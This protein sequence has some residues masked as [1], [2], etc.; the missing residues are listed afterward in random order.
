MMKSTRMRVTPD[1]YDTIVLSTSRAIASQSVTLTDENVQL[2]NDCVAALR[3]GGLLF[4][5]GQ[6]AR[7]PPYAVHLARQLTFKYWIALDIADAP[8]TGALK[9]SH[10]GLLLFWKP[11]G[12]FQINNTTVRVPHATCAACGK[13]LKDWGGKKHL[14][15]PTG[16]AL[17]D[18]WRDL[19]RREI[20][21]HVIPSDVLARI[22]ALTERPGMVFT[23]VVEDAVPAVADRGPAAPSRSPRT[24]GIPT[25][26]IHHTDCVSFLDS[27]PPGSFDLCFADP[28]YNLAKLYSD[29]DDA[30][31]AQEYLAW[32]DRWLTGM[33]RALKPGGALF[34]L[35]LPVWA[36]HHAVLLHRHLEFHHWIA[37]DALSEPR[38]KL[39][40]AH[41]ALLYYTKPG[42][43]PTRNPIPPPAAPTYCL[44]AKCIRER[45]AAGHDQKVEL[46]DIWFDI[47]RI[48]H[49]RDRDHHPCQ[50]PEKL[51][52]RI[53]TM[54]TKPGDVVFDP[55]GG[56]GT[57][58]IVAKQL[59]RQFV[60]TEL[61][62][63]YVR[64]ATERL[65]S[66]GPRARVA[67]P[68]AADSKREVELYLQKLAQTLKRLPT[69]DEI[70]PMMLE[71]IDRLYPYR[72]AA[73][74]R[75]RV[76]LTP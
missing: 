11:G 53:I 33:A 21:E 29:Y 18:V 23:Q 20:H 19:P 9:P 61:D 67:R 73:L 34:V 4:V 59:G 50:L 70:A 56:T 43:P 31:A 71:K 22:Q 69:A 24:A 37:W 15:N 62:P 27:C 68:R 48:R 32:C 63:D 5:Y 26:H 13:P 38:G 46:S 55:F 64:I 58:A 54:T 65:A 6:P 36:I 7:L 40:P 47:H 1:R 25:N 57:T 51:M 17:A 28:P 16:T 44:R 60:L 12:K 10:L 74:K 72:S 75:C 8:R 66:S 3:P 35:N 14:M 45:K 41:Y 52:E 30:R 76:V 2:L 42:S 39:M 49:K